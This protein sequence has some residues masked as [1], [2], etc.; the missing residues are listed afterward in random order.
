MDIDLY[1]RSLIVFSPIAAAILWAVLIYEEM[2]THDF[3]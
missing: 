1:L 2:N 3:W